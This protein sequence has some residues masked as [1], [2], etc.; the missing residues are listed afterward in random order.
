MKVSTECLKGYGQKIVITGA[1]TEVT[2]EIAPELKL[3]QL[4]RVLQQ[5]S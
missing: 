4:S 2:L 3:P 1:N 5:I